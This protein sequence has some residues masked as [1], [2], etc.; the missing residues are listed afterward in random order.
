MNG[1]MDKWWCINGWTDIKLDGRWTKRCVNELTKKA[2]IL[3]Q[4]MK[5]RFN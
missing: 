4:G 5:A 2:Q 1:G 3:E